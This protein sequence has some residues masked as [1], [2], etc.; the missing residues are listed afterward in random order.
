[1]MDA[2]HS[3]APTKD[4]RESAADGEWI[5]RTLTGSASTRIYR[6][7]GCDQEIRPATPHLVAWPADDLEAEQRRHWH[8]SCW[9]SRGHRNP[10]RSRW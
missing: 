5:V 7:P 10:G 2:Q 1:M 4:D 6:C 8:R 3:A 9:R